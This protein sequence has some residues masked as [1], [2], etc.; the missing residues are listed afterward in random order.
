MHTD[1][2]RRIFLQPAPCK[3]SC[4]LHFRL[5][6]VRHKT[7]E[8]WQPCRQCLWLWRILRFRPTPA[9]FGI[10]VN[11]AGN[12]IVTHPVL[13][14]DKIIDHHFPF[15]T[16]RMSQQ[17]KTCN[18]P[19]LQKLRAHSCAF[20]RRSWCRLCSVPRSDFPIQIL[21]SQDDGRTLRRIFSPSTVCVLPS[22]SKT[23]LCP[24]TCTTFAFRWKSIPFLA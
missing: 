16:C 17:R 9:H 5:R 12:G 1:N 20:F 10:G 2:F 19:R 14:S 4:L 13:T 8:V 11:H 21:V 7:S 18:I 15:A 23:T 3:G 24:S 6:N 22:F